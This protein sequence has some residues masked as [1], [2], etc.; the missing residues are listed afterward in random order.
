[1]I[2]NS[3][4]TIITGKASD[5]VLHALEH[6]KRDLNESLGTFQIDSLCAMSQSETSPMT[7][8]L[9]PKLV[10]EK[11]NSHEAE[12]YT[13]SC[14]DNTLT[15]TASDD[16]GFIYGIYEISRRFL[17]IQPLWFW[18][19]QKIER[20][21]SIEIPEG[22]FFF[23]LKPRVR[24]RG[25]FIND[26]VLLANWNIDGDYEKPWEMAFEALLRL[27]GNMTIIGAAAN[28]IVS[29]TSAAKGVKISFLY[30]LKYGVLITFIS[31][32]LSSIY[33]YLRFIM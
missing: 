30:Y 22:F 20:R 18:N 7:H 11:D 24:Y 9:T 19:D 25:W 14:T 6:L 31:L 21:E 4:L 28:V 8:P 23:F 15:I 3:N 10:L 5:P 29:E 26:E 16:L 33:V 17:G 27:G 12:T 1:M 13:L 2:I 32:L